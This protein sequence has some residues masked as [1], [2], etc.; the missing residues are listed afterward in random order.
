M[1]NRLPFSSYRYC[2][3]CYCYLRANRNRT[4]FVRHAERRKCNKRSRE[5]QSQLR[6]THRLFFSQHNYMA[7]I[8]MLTRAHTNTPS[9]KSSIGTHV[10][11]NCNRK[12]VFL[13]R[14]SSPGAGRARPRQPMAGKKCPPKFSLIG[15]RAARVSPSLSF[16]SLQLPIFIIMQFSPFWGTRGFYAPENWLNVM[17]RFWLQLTRKSSVRAHKD[18]QGR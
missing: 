10:H 14:V 9:P 1:V 11:N 7:L 3:C 17:Q 8:G 5:S 16:S 12:T 2:C 18:T 6:D 4:A 13:A 15:A